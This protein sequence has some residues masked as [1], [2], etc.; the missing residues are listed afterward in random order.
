MTVSQVNSSAA[1]L[2]TRSLD[3]GSQ[4]LIARLRSGDAHAL[5]RAISTVENRAAGWSDLL[6]TLFPF[7]GKARIVGVCPARRGSGQEHGGSISS[8]GT[9]AKRNPT[10]GIIAVDP[11]SPYTGGAILGRPHPY[12]GPLRRSVG[13]YIRSMATTRIARRAGAR[14]GGCGHGARCF[15][16][17][18]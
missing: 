7:T 4:S 15:Q 17:A 8:P 9:T 18:T 6:K 1:L 16:A 2:Y 12:A 3:T 11:T 5:A 10:V 14:H 13:F